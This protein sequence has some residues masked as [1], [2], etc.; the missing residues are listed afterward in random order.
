[1]ENSETKEKVQERKYCFCDSFYTPDE[2]LR[3]CDSTSCKWE[4]FHL[5]CVNLKRFPKKKWY[6]PVFCKGNR[7]SSSTDKKFDT[8]RNNERT[9]YF[10]C[11]ILLL[12]VFSFVLTFSFSFSFSFKTKKNNIKAKKKK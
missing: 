11:Y 9:H 6:F 4:G 1:M 2:T 10:S 12:F 8:K 3:E 5:C 7:K